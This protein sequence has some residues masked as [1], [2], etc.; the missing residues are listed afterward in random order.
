MPALFGELA[1]GLKSGYEIG[2]KSK[3]RKAKAEARK[4]KDER[5]DQ[6]FGLQKDKAER[7]KVRFDWDQKKQNREEKLRLAKQQLARADQMVDTNPEAVALML[8]KQT[9]PLFPNGDEVKFVF[10]ESQSE[11][12]RQIW[13]NLLQDGIIPQEMAN[14]NVVAISRKT[15]PRPYNSMKEVLYDAKSM[16]EPGAYEAAERKTAQ[17]IQTKNAAEKIFE[18][19]DGKNYQGQWVADDSG[20]M[21]RIVAEVTDKPIPV[22][23]GRTTKKLEQEETGRGLDI[24][25]KRKK[26]KDGGTKG[27]RTAESKRL[28]ADYKAKID[29]IKGVKAFI[30]K[31]RLD[32]PEPD[33]K[34]V[35]QHKIKLQQLEFEQ[36]AIQKELKGVHTTKDTAPPG[37]GLQ[38]A[39]PSPAAGIQKEPSASGTAAVKKPKP[40]AEQARDTI[41]GAFKAGKLTEEKAHEMTMAFKEEF[42]AKEG[43]SLVSDLIATES[44]EGGE[45]VKR[46]VPMRSADVAK[47]LATEGKTEPTKGKGAPNKV[48][49]VT[50]GAGLAKVR[51]D[52]RVEEANKKITGTPRPLRKG[53]YSPITETRHDGKTKKG[54]GWLGT[55]RT[56]DGKVASEMTV[57][58]RAEGLAGGKDVDIPA[59]V[60]TITMPE[61]RYLLNTD[62][63]PKMWKTPTGKAIMGKAIKWAMK[64]EKEGHDYF[65]GKGEKPY[66]YSG[67]KWARPTRLRAPGAKAWAGTPP[68]GTGLQTRGLQTPGV[69]TKGGSQGMLTRT[70]I[71]NLPSETIMQYLKNFPAAVKLLEP[72]DLKDLPGLQDEA[73]LRK[74]IKENPLKDKLIESHAR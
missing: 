30:W 62:P 58:V 27:A 22:S 49:N 34:G 47:G 14:A 57:G 53:E 45:K 46:G 44:S 11:A 68:Q 3:E 26:L 54:T 71:L 61:L 59:M 72:G 20:N 63:S 31:Y 18:A 64:Q 23:V 48:P 7:E 39:G 28:Q 70:E 67:G 10:R 36:Q 6:K 74:Y 33:Q 66:E 55:F 15:G 42:G 17:L 8:S 52:L 43:A 19:E 41:V 40:T 2:E 29:E 38:E 60:P 16:L 9:Y 35:N 24:D 37:E 13:D 65:I 5:S 1:E 25:I 51:K 50:Q 56:S 32:G 4:K 69:K 21:E 73:A 12:S